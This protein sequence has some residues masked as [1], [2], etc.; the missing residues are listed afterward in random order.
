MDLRRHPAFGWWFANR[1]LFWGA[2]ILLNTF[3]L[4]YII[5]VIGLVEAEAQRYVGRISTMLGL[6]LALATLPSGWMADR[7][8]RRPLVIAAGIAAA[9]GVGAVMLARELSLLTLGGVIIGLAIGVFLSANWA[10]VTDIVPAVEA[11]RYLGIAN[12]AAAS[13]SAVSRFLGGALI[14]VLNDALRSETTGYLV[15][16]GLAAAMFVVSALVALRL[17]AR[18]DCP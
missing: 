5:N 6:A 8:G 2:F 15:M 9:L 1:F 13:G 17:P 7:I 11:A 14:D 18:G 3:L 16:Y 10:L 4:F 12:I